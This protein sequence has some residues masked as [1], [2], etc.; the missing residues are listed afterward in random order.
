MYGV[1][2]K[3]WLWQ[4]LPMAGPLVACQAEVCKTGR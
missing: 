2:I 4:A 3:K 1:G